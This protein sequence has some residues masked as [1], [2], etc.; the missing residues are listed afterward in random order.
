MTSN[1]EAIR[2]IADSKIAKIING[3]EWDI[4]KITDFNRQ[5]ALIG[6]S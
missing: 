5:K 6:W 2:Q 3:M 4:L 1:S